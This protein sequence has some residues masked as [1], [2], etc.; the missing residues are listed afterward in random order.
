M[1]KTCK[2]KKYWIL[3]FVFCFQVIFG[4]DNEAK[5]DSLNVKSKDLKFNYKQIIIPT[6][7]IGYGVIGLNNNSIKSLNED[8]R[9]K[10]KAED[11][12]KTHFDDYLQYVPV[13]TTFGLEAF[14]VKSKNKIKDKLIIAATSTLLMS[15]TVLS[16]KNSTHQLRPDG[17]AYNSFPSGHTATAFMGA[18]MLYQEYKDQS[19]WYGISGYF[20]AATTGYF[21]MYN[22]KH[23]S[24]D[25]LAG[26][27]IGILST[28]AAYWLLPTIN[29]LFK[30]KNTET[31]TVYLPFYDGKT[32]GVGLVSKF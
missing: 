10:I 15:A 14:G 31:K 2:M 13:A 3:V 25:V 5:N 8:Y 24:T 16:L 12:N 22:D 17:S 19:V 27:G 29:K 6:V 4:Q 21:R 7:L 23:W 11:S 20:V 32:F 28:K 9:N 1:H 26:A 18:E 30:N